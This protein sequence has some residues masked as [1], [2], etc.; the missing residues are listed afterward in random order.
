MLNTKQA[1]AIDQITNNQN[2]FI[3]GPGGVG[4]SFLTHEIKNKF[5]DETLFIAPTGIAA[6]NIGGATAHSTFGFPIG[7]LTEHQA[8][9]PSKKCEELFSCD[10]IKRI[11]LDEW[12]MVRA[13]MMRAMDYTL[14]AV[15]KKDIPFGG[16]QLIGSGDFYQLSPILISGSQEE[17]YFKKDFKSPFAFDAPSWEQCGL[18]TIELD[19]VMRQSDEKMVNALN[20]I[21]KK[22]NNFMKSLDFLNEVGTSNDLSQ[23]DPLFLC[24]TNKDADFINNDRYEELDGDEEIYYGSSYGKTKD[25]MVVQNELKC[26]VGMKV[27]ICANNAKRGYYNGQV[28]HIVNLSNDLIGVELDNGGTVHVERYTWEDSEYVVEK[29]KLERRVI[30]RY[31]N[32]PIKIGYAVTIHKSQG[33]SL[34]AACIYTG[35]GLFAHGQAYVALSR[36]RSLEGLCLVNPIRYNEIIVD[37]RVNDFYNGNIVKN[38]FS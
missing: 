14:R 5:G 13:D 6:Q 33:L 3:T 19:Q 18:E 25:I 12:S 27:L 31:T 29:E 17:H 32:F 34:D 30:G 26:K 20:S 22:D 9:R 24:G 15:K 38:L 7:F 16:L 1:Y 10:T 36:L 37:N 35:R 21:R 2:V 11:F 8:K 23:S 4:K 28:G